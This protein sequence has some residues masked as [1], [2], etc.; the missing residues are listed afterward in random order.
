MSRRSRSQSHPKPYLSVV[1][2]VFNEVEALAEL[3]VRLDAVL[4]GIGHSYEI[5]FVDDGSS[6]GSTQKL[7]ATVQCVQ[8]SAG[9]K[10]SIMRP[11]GFSCS[12]IGP[13]PK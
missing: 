4:N 3:Y 1:V 7:M 11:V 5:L 6:D 8:R 12:L 10:R 9:V 13:R 2:P